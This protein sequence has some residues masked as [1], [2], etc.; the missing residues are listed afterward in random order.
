MCVYRNSTRNN[1]VNNNSRGLYL[2][3]EALLRLYLLVE[4]L[5]RL[6]LLVGALLRLCLS[7]V[8][9]SSL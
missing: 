5:L 3:V 1:N 7:A 2:L 4:A 8:A 6:Y 9:L